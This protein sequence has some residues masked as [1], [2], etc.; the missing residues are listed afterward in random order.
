MEKTN[1]LLFYQLGCELKPIIEYKYKF[2]E[3]LPLVRFS[4]R[5][6]S[7]LKKLLDSFTSLNVCR[8][9][10]N[11][12][13]QAFETIFDWLKEVEAKTISAEDFQTDQKFINVIEKAT[14]FEPILLAELQTLDA[15]HVTQKGIYDTTSLIDNADNTLPPSVLTKL[16]AEV[17]R[18]IRESGRCLAFD[19]ATASGFHIMRA[20]EC[21]MHQYL[22][23]VCNPKPKP[24]ERL[25]NWGA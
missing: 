2:S 15:Y 8:T 3:R 23:H 18:E 17:K 21:V 20:T 11:Q 12:C 22:L 9:S 24:K 19:N 7:S 14:Q 1:L 10:G 25:P 6:H 13:I 16:T 4:L 5:A